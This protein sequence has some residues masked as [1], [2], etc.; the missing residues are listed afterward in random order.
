MVN[1]LHI[2]LLFFESPDTVL[3]NFSH[4]PP[5]PPLLLGLVRCSTMPLVCGVLAASGCWNPVLLECPKWVPRGPCHMGFIRIPFPY[6]AQIVQNYATV[7]S[8]GSRHVHFCFSWS[9]YSSF[10]WDKFNLSL[11]TSRKMHNSFEMG[12]KWTA[13]T[14]FP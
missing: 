1:A 2:T 8:V 5:F 14:K 11:I 10:L 3:F 7:Y 4:T 6:D 9:L 13:V 12:T